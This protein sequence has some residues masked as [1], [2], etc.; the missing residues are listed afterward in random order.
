MV[1]KGAFGLLRQEAASLAQEPD[2]V[3]TLLVA[4]A[5]HGL[6]LENLSDEDRRRIATSLASAAGQL[7][8][9][10][11]MDPSGPD[12]W[13]ASLIKYLPVLEMWMAGLAEE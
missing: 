5:N 1:S 11:L 2:D 7:R 8:Q 10:L 13:T 6:F 9:R 4:E 12:G 3:L